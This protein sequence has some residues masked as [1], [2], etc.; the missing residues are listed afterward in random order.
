[1][2]LMQTMAG[3]AVGG[4][5]EFFV[6]LA[7]GFQRAGLEQTIVTRPNETRNPRLKEAGIE[8]LELPFG[9]MF[10]FRT[11]S[12]LAA[13]IDRFQPDIVLS[14]M[15]RAS[16]ITGKAVAKAAAKASAR[17]VVIGRLGGYYDLKYYAGCDHLIGNTP[18]ITRY[19]VDK[20]WPEARAHFVPNFVS[21]VPG[22]AL[23]RSEFNIPEYV[24]LLLAAGRLHRNK[25]YDVLLTALKN[26]PDCHL[27]L[28][29]D[30]G[31]ARELESLAHKL[32]VAS[33]VRFLGWRGDIA[34]LMATADMLICPSR[35]EPLGNVVIEAWARNLP[36]VA[37]ASDGPAWLIKDGE[38]GL[39]VPVED[40]DLLSDAIQRFTADPG[41]APRLAAG[42]RRRFEAEFTES[43]VIA[44]FLELFERVRG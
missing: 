28:A 35:I 18:D 29:G 41:L 36:V 23:P 3:G 31:D 43:V 17:L 20:G 30:G 22:A 25:A 27:L 2:K 19:L 16:S 1:M 38:D 37:A 15:S 6:R 34:N 39:L 14:W 40:V 21:A 44:R 12:D 4:A 32:G 7:T 26:L 42:G 5:E 9:G 11:V 24:P 13:E 8:P 33:R 10:D